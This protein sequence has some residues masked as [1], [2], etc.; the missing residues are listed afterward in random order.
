M[1]DII[2]IYLLTAAAACTETPDTS[3]S[4]GNDRSSTAD[5]ISGPFMDERSARSWIKLANGS[6][7][8]N[9]QNLRQ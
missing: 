2:L 5:E 8:H 9:A 4:C 7:G 1:Y 3:P 6:S